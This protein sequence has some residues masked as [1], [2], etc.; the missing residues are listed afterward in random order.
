[1]HIPK[2]LVVDDLS[3]RRAFLAKLGE[4]KDILERRQRLSS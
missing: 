1:M 3:Q 4:E 2:E